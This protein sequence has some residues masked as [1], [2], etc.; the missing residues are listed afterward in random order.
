MEQVI[1][2]KYGELTTKKANRNLFI[3]TLYDNI[4]E[5]LKDYQVK[6]TK[7]RVRMFIETTDNIDEIVNILSNIPG[8][9]GI[10]IAY[11][12]DTNTEEIKAKTLDIV[13]TINFK[14]FKVETKRSNKNFPIPSMEFNQIIGRLLL[15]NIPNIKVDVHNPDYLLKIEIRDKYTYIYSKEINGLGGY[16]IGVAGKGLLMLSGGID[17]PV[18]GY[19]AMKRGIKLECIYFESPPHTSIQAKNKVKKLVAKLNNYQSNITLH[20]INFTKIQE[21]IYQNIN[22]NYM[23]TIMRRMMYRIS[24]KVAEKNNCLAIINGE[25]V[26]QVASQTLTSMQVINNVTSYPIIRPL[27]CYD[28]LDI[29]DISKKIDTYETSILP[30]EDCCTIFLPKHPVINPSLDKAIEYEKNIDYEEL[31]EEAINN[32]ENIKITNNEDKFNI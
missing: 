28:K 3:K 16:P 32:M 13:K 31:I 2:I 23:I 29:I 27:A 24:T 22:P 1:L 19:L 10:V 20:V 14:T 4:L 15:K 18:A 21:A 9:H 5:K 12:V 17:S 8:I 11:K 7:D 30:Y 25:S 6:I 26:G